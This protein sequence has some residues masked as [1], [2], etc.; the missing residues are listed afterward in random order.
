MEPSYL[1][2]ILGF[3]SANLHVE[4]EA[5]KLATNHDDHFSSFRVSCTN[6]DNPDIL[7]DPLLWPQDCLFRKWHPPRRQ[8]TAGGRPPGN[9]DG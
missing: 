1:A 7:L 3:I 6:N 4:V 2:L 5:E 9:D 8:M